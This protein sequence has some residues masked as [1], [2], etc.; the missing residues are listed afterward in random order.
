MWF[1]LFVGSQMPPCH[2]IQWLFL[3][4]HL[5]WCCWPLPASSNSLSLCFWDISL[6]CFSFLLLLTVLCLIFSDISSF[7]PPALNS[8]VPQ[9][10]PKP[11]LCF[12]HSVCFPYKNLPMPSAVI[13]TNSIYSSIFISSP[14]F[15]LQSRS[16]Y[17][18]AY[19]TSPLCHLNDT[20]F[21]KCSQ[22]NKWSSSTN[23]LN[24]ACQPTISSR[25]WSSSRIWSTP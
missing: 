2:W 14:E 18:P 6:S 3:D 10:C 8:V 25:N 7:F 13:T 1:L 24:F 19:L 17:S 5:T 20:S 22:P 12:T 23:S 9:C 21:L 15:P 16:I 11:I 4:S